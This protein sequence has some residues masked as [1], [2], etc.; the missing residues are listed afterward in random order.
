[1]FVKLTDTELVMMS[2]AAQRDDRDLEPPKS[3]KAST[4]AKVAAKL[5]ASGLVREIKTKKRAA[6]WRRD[7]KTGQA[8]SLK[9]TAAGLKAIVVDVE[10]LRPTV[11]DASTHIHGSLFPWLRE[12]VDPI[13]EALGRLVTTLDVIGLEAFVPEP[14]CGRGRPPE[15]RR[16]LARAFVAKAMLGVQAVELAR[17]RLADAAAD[18]D[19]IVAPDRRCPCRDRAC[20]TLGMVVLVSS[21]A[22]LRRHVRPDHF[23]HVE[24]RGDL[25]ERALV[26]RRVVHLAHVAAHDFGLQPSARHARGLRTIAK[27]LERRQFERADAVAP[28]VDER[29]ESVA[30]GPELR[31]RGVVGL[32]AKARVAQTNP[33]T[34]FPSFS[35]A[36][37][38]L[39]SQVS[40]RPRSAPEALLA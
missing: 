17:R 22:V 25:E 38:C 37:R 20:G 29:M 24:L 35:L 30:F 33:S 27:R 4:A 12:E 6:A 3:M 10:D 7:E 32:F 11:G 40:P 21:D 34:R 15:D 2:A 31:A 28:A 19:E 16:A 23:E 39:P 13:T 26:F 9:L 5:I 8:Y 18:G 36:A 1:M 14:P